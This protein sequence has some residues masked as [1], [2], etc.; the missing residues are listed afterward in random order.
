[1]APICP[2][3]QIHGRAAQCSQMVWYA[4]ND[5][6]SFNQYDAFA[7]LFPWYMFIL[8]L[9]LLSYCCVLSLPWTCSRAKVFSGHQ[10]HGESPTVVRHVRSGLL[11]VTADTSCLGCEIRRLTWM[12]LFVSIPRPSAGCNFSPNQFRLNVLP[13]AGNSA[14]GHK[15][16]LKPFWPNSPAGYF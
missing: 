10:P 11:V 9:N 3:Q 14:R 2:H 16:R 15:L 12:C 4:W 8:M 6:T 7:C 13:E 1:M 5:S